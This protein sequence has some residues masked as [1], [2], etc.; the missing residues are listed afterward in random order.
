[1]AHNKKLNAA[2]ATPVDCVVGPTA[3]ENVS[4]GWSPDSNS[5]SNAC[6]R[7][8]TLGVVTI[9][10]V[11]SAEMVEKLHSH[12]T[13]DLAFLE[14]E[15]QRQAQSLTADEHHRAVSLHRVDF[16]EIVKRDGGRVDMRY[17][18]EQSP[19]TDSRISY[20]SIVFPFMKHL[21][22][23]EDVSLLYM[24]VM[25]A[26]QQSAESHQK[27]HGDGGQLFTGSDAGHLP[28]HCINVFI[29]LVDL[30]D[31]NGPTEFAVGTHVAGKFGEDQNKFSVCCD[32]GSAVIFDYR[33]K[34][35]GAANKCPTD[36]PVL[37]MA[38]SRPW[39][40]DVGNSRSYLPLVPA[41]KP[42]RSRLLR[43]SVVCEEQA[44]V[45]GG[46]KRQRVEG[47]LDGTEDVEEDGSGEHWILF[48]MAVQLN[49]DVAGKIRVHHGDIP[50]DLAAQFVRKHG[51][52]PECVAPLTSSI[53]EQI[54]AATAKAEAPEEQ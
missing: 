30:I 5:F 42:W 23:G 52:P 40:K 49:D 2:Y 20:N 39:F 12:A 17:N 24:G 16:R 50:E 3:E 6:K 22:G 29:P 44:H 15:L 53:A 13:T 31:E 25:F 48:E 11:L 41:S 27:W 54:A 10:N 45:K 18:L 7:F 36:R 1:M 8:N 35:R 28:A 9:P 51:L 32:A 19:Y 14:N 21:L 26:Q 33:I 43:G 34:H 46:H 47:G 37:Y 38:Y 4:S